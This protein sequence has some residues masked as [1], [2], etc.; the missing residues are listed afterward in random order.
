MRRWR[1]LC[2][3]LMVTLLPGCAVEIERPALE[4]LGM[5]GVMGFDYMSPNQTKVVVSLPQPSQEAKEITQVYKTIADLPSEALMA[6]SVKSEK[7]M[8]LAQLR[9]VLFNETY[10]RKVGIRK[11]VENF[12]RNPSVGDNVFIAIV[13][14]SVEDLMMAKYENKPEFNKFL[15]DLLHPRRE[16]AFHSFINIHE[17]MYRLKAGTSDID[18]PYL[19]KQ[20]GDIQ[21]TKVALFAEDKMIGFLSQ[22]EGKIVQALR[23]RS[24]LPDMDFSVPEE[25]NSRVKIVVNF[26]SSSA[27]NKVR[28]DLDA[29]LIQINLTIRNRILAYSGQRNLEKPDE[30]VALEKGLEHEM[31][32]EAMKLLRKLQKIGV[33]PCNLTEHVRARYHGEW[34]KELARKALANAKFE[35]HTNIII[36]GFGTIS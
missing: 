24:Q 13:K 6:L 3:L 33:E 18:M 34:N 9:V 26:V 23:E 14:G 8:S 2:M 15:N 22:R 10:A 30:W 27:K 11:V 21:I 31:N 4:D 35:V 20:Q 16:T 32:R 12:Y 1:V 7:S 25:G 36:I 17:T 28:G 19:E 29:P 5:I